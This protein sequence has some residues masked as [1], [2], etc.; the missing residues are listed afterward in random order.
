MGRLRKIRK[1]LILEKIIVVEES[2]EEKLNRLH[3]NQYQEGVF[4]HNHIGVVT[5]FLYMVG[6]Y[7]N[8]RIEEWIQKG[9][10]HK[11]T[12]IYLKTRSMQFSDS[13]FELGLY[14]WEDLSGQRHYL[15]QGREY[16][17]F[18]RKEWKFV[19]NKPNF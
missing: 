18:G 7:D 2:G 4:H 12:Q 5:V 15:G 6:Q 10:L 19:F 8:F 17:V 11:T 1:K 3:N 14:H 16:L 13:I 9:S